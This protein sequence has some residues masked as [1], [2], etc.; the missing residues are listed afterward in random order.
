MREAPKVRA[1]YEKNHEKGF[2]I[3]A[4]SLDRDPK[5]LADYLD[6][7]KIPWANLSGADARDAAQK[8]GIR[9]IPTMLL[10]DRKGKVVAVGNSVAKLETKLNEML[11]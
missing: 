2:D 10:L 4:I 7:A 3:L 9:A 8:Y 1:L 11:K 5:A 6:K